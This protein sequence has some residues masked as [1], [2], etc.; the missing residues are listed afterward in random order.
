MF[1]EENFASTFDERALKREERARREDAIMK[2]EILP[3][4]RNE[5]QF[6]LAYLL[7]VEENL[8]ETLISKNK[9]MDYWVDEG[10]S[11]AY[12]LLEQDPL[13]KD[14]PRLQ[15]DFQ[16][17]TIQDVIQYKKDGTLLG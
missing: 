17:I 5:E 14:H 15:G 10:Y 7:Y 13:F 16:N 6:R 4:N 2:G 9:I 11:S 3:T 8:D 1:K 12:R